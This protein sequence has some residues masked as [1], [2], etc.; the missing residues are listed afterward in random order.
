MK[1]ERPPRA[2][3]DI[4]PHISECITSSNS[5]AHCLFPL[6]VSLSFFLPLEEFTTSIELCTFLRHSFAVLSIFNSLGNVMSFWF[7]LKFMTKGEK[8]K[9]IDYN[10][11]SALN[12]WSMT[13]P[14]QVNFSIFLIIFNTCRLTEDPFRC[15]IMEGASMFSCFGIEM[16]HF[17]LIMA[18]VILI[19][20]S[21]YLLLRTRPDFAESTEATNKQVL[22]SL[23]PVDYVI[24]SLFPGV[25]EELLFRGAL[26]PL[27]GMDWKS[28]LLVALVFGVLHLGNGRKYSF[29]YSVVSCGWGMFIFFSF[30]YSGMLGILRECQNFKCDE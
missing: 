27:F 1:Y 14:N 9:L 23:Q 12:S 22:T 5:L 4:G 8:L 21:R 3:V 10:T 28:V 2:L 13:K 17:E 18:S 20:S 6:K 11:K 25:S 29:V 24:V 16:W 30:G 15:Q 26:Q 19:S 7:M